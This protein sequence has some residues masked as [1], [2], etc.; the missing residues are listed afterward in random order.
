MTSAP[1]YRRA[2]FVGL[3]A[4]L[5][6]VSIS[7]AITTFA[8]QSLIVYLRLFAG[9]VLL[10]SVLSVFF[11]YGVNKAQI[12][13]LYVFALLLS[14]GAILSVFMGAGSTGF[15]NIERDFLVGILGVMVLGGHFSDDDNSIL[16]ARVYCFYAVFVLLFTVWLGGL[17]L[18]FPPTFRF[19][20]IASSIGAAE[21]QTYSLGI[22]NFFGLAAVAAAFL[23]SREVR[24]GLSFLG[25][26]MVVLFLL[27]SMLGGGRGESLAAFGVV[28]LLVTRKIWL[29]AALM[30]LI[31][32]FSYIGMDVLKSLE[33][34]F[35]FIKRFLVLFEGS[36][37]S[38]DLLLRQGYDLLRDNPQCLLIGCGFGYFQKYYQYGFEYYPHNVFV[39]SIISYGLPLVLCGLLSSLAGLVL[40][41]RKV[42][43]LDLLSVFFVYALIVSLKSGYLLGSWMVLVF[44]CYFTGSAVGRGFNK[45]RYALS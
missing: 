37:S 3:V 9:F 26:C 40:H 29:A 15:V 32:G 34:D 24:K 7:G 45:A 39:E 35:L 33:S 44:F 16:L 4:F 25:V 21:E 20:Y 28:F 8:A 6:L 2:E 18:D 42:G 14:Y 36:L 43:S 19:E 27:L 41:I 11:M 5:I 23:A 12:Y 30:S 10:G 31:V 13:A 1:L 22:S 38:R 17:T